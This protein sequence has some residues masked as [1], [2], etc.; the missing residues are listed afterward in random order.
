MAGVWENDPDLMQ[1]EL[2][3]AIKHPLHNTHLLWAAGKDMHPAWKFGDED[4]VH[5][6]LD[7]IAFLKDHSMLQVVLLQDI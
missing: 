3:V 2:S 4:P 6:L 7:W 5:D 1:H